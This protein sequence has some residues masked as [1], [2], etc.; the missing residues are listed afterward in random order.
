MA[1]QD[2]IINKNERSLERKQV[3]LNSQYLI[4]YIRYL[5]Y[6]GLET[7]LGKE[8][9]ERESSLWQSLLKPN[10]LFFVN[11]QEKKQNWSFLNKKNSVFFDP[12]RLVDIRHV[13]P[14]NNLS[15]YM[16]FE[17]E[18]PKKSEKEFKCYSHR[19]LAN[20]LSND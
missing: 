17:D 19:Q 13:F 2:Y 4:K 9:E 3:H 14:P 18:R 8:K 10:E 15:R 16:E 5:E 1:Y 11:M 12:C 20:S 6:K 7:I